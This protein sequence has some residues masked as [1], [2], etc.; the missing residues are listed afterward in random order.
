MASANERLES[1]ERRIATLEDEQAILKRLYDYSYAL[2]S[3]DREA[4]LDCFTADHVRT[5]APVGHWTIGSEYRYEGVDAMDYY[6]EGHTHAPD[7]FHMH[8]LSQPRILVSG[9]TAT[10]EAYVVRVDENVEGPYI[11]SM[12]K[13]NDILVRCDDGNWRFKERRL[14]LIG[15]LDREFSAKVSAETRARN[16]KPVPQGTRPPKT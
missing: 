8:F 6:F 4:W 10:N 3:G 11:E 5:G 9:D 14:T 2:D 16:K 13:Y 1:I 12:A 7:L 15:W